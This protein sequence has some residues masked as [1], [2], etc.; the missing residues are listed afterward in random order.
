MVNTMTS[1]I[2]THTYAL[3]YTHANGIHDD[4]FDRD[5]YI[6]THYTMLPPKVYTMTSWIGAHIY[7][8]HHAH[9]DGIHD[10]EFDRGAYI[11]TALCTC[12]WSTRSQVL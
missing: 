5:A 9:T 11:H 8:L 3:H 6:Y 10:D 7:T 12:H 4:E 2:G 1:L